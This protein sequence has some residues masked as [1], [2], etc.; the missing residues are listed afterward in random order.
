MVTPD[1][2][3]DLVEKLLSFKSLNPD[4]LERIGNKN[5]I[6]A[7]THFNPKKLKSSMVDILTAS[8]SDRSG[9]D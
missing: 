1:H 8:A 4:D 2:I 7:E 6:I 5:R 3:E 9:D